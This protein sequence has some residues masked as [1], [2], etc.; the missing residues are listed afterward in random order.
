MHH[1]FSMSFV[2][3]AGGSLMMNSYLN[4][5][6]FRLS[7]PLLL[8]VNLGIVSFPYSSFGNKALSNALNQPRLFGGAELMYRA[9]EN[10]FFKVGVNIQP[11]Y[12]SPYRSARLN[13]FDPY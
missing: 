2:G 13:P 1:T 12:L 10:T 5:M 6:M 3:G 8:K 4:T 11:A 7:N 9:S